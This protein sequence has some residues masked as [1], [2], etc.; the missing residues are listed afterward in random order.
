MLEII[1]PCYADDFDKLNTYTGSE[2][3]SIKGSSFENAVYKI[4]C[5]SEQE[6]TQFEELAATS[7]LK[8]SFNENAS[9]VSN[10]TISHRVEQLKRRRTTQC[11]E[12]VDLAW[13]CPTTNIV[14]RL[15]G[16]AG[17]LKNEN[18]H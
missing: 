13:I 11:S 5:G 14:E 10:N 7:L 16:Q 3:L 18:R 17:S 2:V 4:L 8:P 6:M 1:C 9:D 15:F 12:Y